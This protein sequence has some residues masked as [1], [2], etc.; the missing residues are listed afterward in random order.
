M[1]DHKELNELILDENL[2][3]TP[4][5]QQAQ[6][7]P[8]EEGTDPFGSDGIDDENTLHFVG[9]RFANEEY[10]LEII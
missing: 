2:F 6:T 5:Q 7:P 8:S 1:M 9:F 4:E 3:F 10:I